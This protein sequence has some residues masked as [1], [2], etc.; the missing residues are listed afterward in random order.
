M[1]KQISKSAFIAD[2][3][4][5]LTKKA[6]MEKYELPANTVANFV[7][8]LGL[9]LKRDITPK[10]ILVDDIKEVEKENLSNYSQS[11]SNN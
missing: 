11:E 8:D 2:I 3:E 9:T 10:Y 1:S 4:N 6:L 7:K 5:G